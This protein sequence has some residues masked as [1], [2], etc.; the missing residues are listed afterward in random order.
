MRFKSLLAFFH[1]PHFNARC[2][3]KPFYNEW[4]FVINS[5][6]TVKHEHQQH[7]K[8][9]VQC[10]FLQINDCV[11][12]LGR[13]LKAGNA[14]FLIFFYDFPILPIFYK[15]LA[16][17]PLHGDVVVMVLTDVYLLLCGNSV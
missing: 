11:T 6:D 17:S 2:L 9:L 7:V 12:V 3:D 14:F 15:F 1:A 13:H 5:S 4:C 16:G 8:F 10:R